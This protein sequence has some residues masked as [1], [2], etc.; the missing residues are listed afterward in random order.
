MS[1]NTP[2]PV[3]GMKAIE[4]SSGREVFAVYAANRLGNM[5]LNVEGKFYSDKQFSKLFDLVQKTP[6]QNIVNVLRGKKVLFIEN[7]NGLYHGLDAFEAILK[8]NKIKYKCLFEVDKMPIDK[9]IKNILTHDAIVFQT[10]WVEAVSHKL[11]D[12]MFGL[13]EKKIVIECF[14]H[15]PSWYYKPD[16]VHDVYIHLFDELDNDD[17]NSGHRFYKLS[18]TAYWEYIN[19]FDK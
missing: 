19:E 17:G 11:R 13:Q 16:V 1:T 8:A 10:R 15:E 18:E 9:I 4:I 7:D 2:Q 14:I 5:R 3:K 12:Y 6:R